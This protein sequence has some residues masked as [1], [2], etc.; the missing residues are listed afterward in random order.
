MEFYQSQ[1]NQQREVMPVEENRGSDQCHGM[2]HVVKKG[3]TLYKIARMHHVS[4]SE[5][6]YVNPYVNVYQLQPG[7]EICVPVSNPQNL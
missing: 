2:I 7:D 6:M 4:V 5:L 1:E 3:D